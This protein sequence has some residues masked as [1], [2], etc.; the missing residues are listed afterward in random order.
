[1]K[2]TIVFFA[3]STVLS[4]SVIAQQNAQSSYKEGREDSIENITVYAQKR[5]Q[6]IKDVSVAVSV[7]SDE[8]LEQ[9]NIKD[10]TLLSAQLPNVKITA[11]TGEGAPPVLNIRGVGSLDY[12]NTTTAPVAVYVDNIAGGALSN[13]GVYLFDVEHIE[14]L[15]GP[16][17]TLFGRNTTG[18]AILINSKRPTYDTEGFV[19]LGLANQDHVTA[20]GVFNTAISDNTAVRLGFSHQDYDYSSNNLEPGFP[21]AGMR[22]NYFRILLQHQADNYQYL[23]KL[24]AEDWKGNVKPVRSKGYIAP[25]GST[26]APSQAGTLAC[27]DN[28]GFNVGSDDF[29]DVRLD[30]DSPHSTK[31]EGMSL[32]LSYDLSDHSSLISISGYNQLDRIHTFNCDASPARLCDGDLGVDSR[33]FTQELRIN[34]ELGEHYLI[35]GLFFIDEQIEQDN[36]I[37]LFYDFRAITADGPAHFFYDNQVDIQSIAG[38]G[39]FDYRINDNWSL[40]AGL[41]FTG[42]ET[43]YRATS[44]INVPTEVGDFNGVLVPGWDFS[45]KIS[46]D[47]FSGKLALNNNISNHLSI[48]YS[49]SRGFKSGGYNG[50]LAFSPD[51]ARLAEYGPET[52]TAWE[53][54]SKATYTDFNVNAAIFYY[55][56][57]MEWILWDPRTVA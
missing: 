37:D 26:C 16:Q 50:S 56:S 5:P 48:Y 41:R 51:E 11:N 20:E 31:R 49:L 9:L 55:P 30:D 38:F 45:G 53:I 43:D 27:T 7:L 17:G 39:Q 46:D 19:D 15:K 34:H 47:E 35:A 1:M 36:R 40:T 42:E 32:E 2:R 10:T 4:S 13:S 6:D 3:V 52:I 12:N 18:G 25:D 44:Q 33:V 29:H 23:L 14:V 24:Y 8:I 28:F 54:G 22:Q 57:V 21:Q